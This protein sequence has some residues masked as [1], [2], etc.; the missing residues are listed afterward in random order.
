MND[1]PLQTALAAMLRFWSVRRP[2]P[3]QA[4]ETFG[5]GA[6]P[7]GVPQ[8]GS[9]FATAAGALALPQAAVSLEASGVEV[10][11]IEPQA[12]SAQDE[13]E[14]RLVVDTAKPWRVSEA[15]SGG[16][17]P[18]DTPERM[19]LGV[20]KPWRV[21]APALGGGGPAEIPDRM[22]LDMPKPW[23]AGALE[24]EGSAAQL[25]Q[26]MAGF[27]PRGAGEVVVG[28]A[29]LGEWDRLMAVNPG[30]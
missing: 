13:G 5:E 25:V 11:P 18:E 9:A 4:T 10:G 29:R 12:L 7:D 3:A 8:F 17:A 14:D 22:T 27:A 28:A 16:G 1:N 15:D 2:G 23:L 26:A 24:L 21:E 30:A 19:V 6:A 20:V